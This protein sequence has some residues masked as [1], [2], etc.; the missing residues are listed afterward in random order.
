[1]KAFTFTSLTTTVL[2]CRDGGVPGERTGRQLIQAA[3]TLPA[4]EVTPFVSIDSRG[5]F[6][7]GV[8]VN[9]PLKLE[10]QHRDRGRLP[11]GRRRIERTQL[12]RESSVRASANGPN[13]AVSRDRGRVSPNTARRLF[14]VKAP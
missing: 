13:D 1:M 7:V 6:P 4:V 8:A 2:A 3:V 12:E 14:P 5:S 9:F 10:L 11:S